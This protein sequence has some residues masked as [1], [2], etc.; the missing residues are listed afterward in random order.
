MYRVGVI[1]DKDSVLGF[2]AIG[3]EAF[4]AENAA[5]AEKLLR[6]MAEQNFAVLY[7]TEQYAAV[8]GN[9][10][11][12]YRNRRFPAIIP[13]PGVRG[14]LGVGMAGVKQCVEKAVGA[15]ILFND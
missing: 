6:E 15:D 9:V 4:P 8:L 3:F 10:T 14:G 11:A 5:E 12:M 1:G 7:L 2:T 13:I